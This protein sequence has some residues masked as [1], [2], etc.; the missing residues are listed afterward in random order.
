MATKSISDDS[1]RV[2]LRG[3]ME[4]YVERALVQNINRGFTNHIAKNHH[5]RWQWIKL[6]AHWKTLVGIARLPW[7]VARNHI[8]NAII[9]FWQNEESGPK[10]KVGDKPVEMP[11]FDERPDSASRAD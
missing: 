9:E 5:V 6:K 7:P 10:R 3:E 4:A 8:K 11:E 1:E 2:V